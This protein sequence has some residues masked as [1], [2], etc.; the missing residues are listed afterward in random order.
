MNQ[1]E[2]SHMPTFFLPRSHAC[3]S[4]PFTLCLSILDLP[5]AEHAV[6]GHARPAENVLLIFLCAQ[7]MCVPLSFTLIPHPKIQLF[8][9]DRKHTNT[10]SLARFHYLEVLC[11]AFGASDS[12]TNW[13]CCIS[14][15]AFR[16]YI[17]HLPLPLCYVSRRKE[18][19]VLIPANAMSC[20]FFFKME[21]IGFV[22]CHV[23]SVLA[24]A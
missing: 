2:D 16:L 4:Y 5:S 20:V 7:D 19:A 23:K 1:Q 24:F 3:I 10:R 11:T 15:Q 13:A 6:V 18:F 21:C 8:Y 12:R 14:H 17:C 22:L 9:T